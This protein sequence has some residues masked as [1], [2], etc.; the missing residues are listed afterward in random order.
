[1]VRKRLRAKVIPPRR[2]VPPDGPATNLPIWQEAFFGIEILLLHASPVYFG[3]GVPRGD[4]SGVVIIPGF[5]ASDIYLVELYAWLKRLGY[6]PFFS[7]IGVN[8]DCPNLLIRRRL[9]ETIDRARRETGNRVHLLGHSLGGLLA[10]SAAAERETD[11]ASVITLGSPFKGTVL[12][13]RVREAVESVRLRILKNNGNQV[14]P[15]CYTSGCTCSFLSSL[16]RDMPGSIFQTAVYSRS[17]GFVDWRYCTTGVDS[18][19][20]EVAGT[21]IGLAFNPV[22]YGIIGDRL[23]E[24]RRPQQPPLSK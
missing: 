10:R 2:D 11:V 16:L 22:A 23:A 6:R 13:P 4:G 12:H 18:N 17:D 3:F 5:L 7:G 8:N 15:D 19:D 14:L 1:L 24:A 20:F 9:N 21:H